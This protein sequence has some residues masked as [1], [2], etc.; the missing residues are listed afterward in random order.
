MWAL[1]EHLCWVKHCSLCKLVMRRPPFLN[2]CLPK[3]ILHSCRREAEEIII[4]Y[5]TQGS[6]P[7]LFALLCLN[8]IS[9]RSL[10]SSGTFK[11]SVWSQGETVRPLRTWF[12]ALEEVATVFT[13][14]V[15]QDPW[16]ACMQPVGPPQVCL[17]ALHV[18]L[19]AVPSLLLQQLQEAAH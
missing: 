14:L 19:Q 12:E 15:V 3:C 8:F 18:H 9:W 7:K 4:V 13:F 11:G 2:P 1:A 17:S 10:K 16:E 5:Y 6:I